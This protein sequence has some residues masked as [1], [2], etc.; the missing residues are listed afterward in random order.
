MSGKTYHAQPEQKFPSEQQAP[1]LDRVRLTLVEA[2]KVI[3]IP[4]ILQAISKKE[5]VAQLRIITI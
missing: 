5:I 2:N 4:F 1:L 3:D